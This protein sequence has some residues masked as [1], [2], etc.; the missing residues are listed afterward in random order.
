[1]SAALESPKVLVTACEASKQEWADCAPG[2]QVKV[3]AV[4]EVRNSVEY[5][6]K[7]DPGYHSGKHKHMCET[8][9]YV[10]AGSLTNHTIECEFGPG[11]FC[12]QPFDDVHVEEAGS[13]GA[14]LY[15]SLR[16]KTGT[17]IEFYD[18]EDQVCGKFAV[19]DF[20]QLLPA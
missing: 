9:A 3:L 10:L 7:I 12:Y 2:V 5:L 18:D 8:Y 17:L 4:D 16:G 13:E 14:T 1:M 19:N 6:I 15:V 11:D 20:A